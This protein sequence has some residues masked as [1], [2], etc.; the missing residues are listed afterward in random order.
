MQ[1]VVKSLTIM[2]SNGINGD[3]SSPSEDQPQTEV[4]RAGFFDSVLTPPDWFTQSFLERVLQN[5][6]QDNHLKVFGYCAK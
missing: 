4:K 1:S 3:S 5:D 2:A 6:K